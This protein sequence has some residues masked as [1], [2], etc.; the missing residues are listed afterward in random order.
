MFKITN[1]EPQKHDPQRLNVY[2]DGEFAFGVARVIAP[3]L[4]VGEQISPETVEEL[5]T[6]DKIEKAYQ[7]ALNFLSYRTRSTSEVEQNL[8]KHDVPDD[9]IVA[10]L[11]RL[12]EKSLLNDLDFARKWVE[13]RAAFHP[14]GRRALASELRQ[15]GVSRKII[16]RVLEDVDDYEMAYKVAQNKL[17]RI[18]DLERPQ[19]N[20]KLY[21][22]LSRRG[23]H[24]GICKEIANRVWDDLKEQ[25][26]QE[27]ST[28]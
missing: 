15:K 17:R 27:N 6:K 26:E 9:V 3:W 16:D 19:F 2:L 5:K 25:K 8:R 10:V 20:K 28:V 13:N 14:R 4:K 24:Y 21:G 18:K 7:R 1:L 22:Y 11:D 23:F 12:Q